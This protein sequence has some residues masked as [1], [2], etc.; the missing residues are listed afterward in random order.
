[1]AKPAYRNTVIRVE[2]E[3]Y[4]LLHNLQQATNRPI[5]YITSQALSYALKHVK[6][7]EVKTYDVAFGDGKEG[8]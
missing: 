5:G 3:I 1:M 4:D 7:V 2:P 6:M 8:K